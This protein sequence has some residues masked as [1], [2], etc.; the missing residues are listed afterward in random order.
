MPDRN[1]PVY[2]QPD[3]NITVPCSNVDKAA[4]L[5]PAVSLYTTCLLLPS[6]AAVSLKSHAHS[7]PPP[8]AGRCS[9]LTSTGYPEA[10]GEMGKAED[11]SEA[12]P[13]QAVP[14]EAKAKFCSIIAKPLADE[15]LCKKVLKLCKKASKAKAIRRGVKEVVKA[16]RKKQKG[17]CILAGD[18]SPIDVLTHIPIVCEDHQI[19]Y[20]YVPSKEELGAAALSKRPTSCMLVLP[21]PIK[22]AADDAGAAEYTEAYNELEKKIKSV[23]PLF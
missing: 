9:E 2:V 15:K 7:R 4:A 5:N 23:M 6:L 12:A 10:Q 17:I 14:Y 16:L 19:P 8:P 22:P 20:I 11:G 1:C 18:I 21:K 13:V 3:C